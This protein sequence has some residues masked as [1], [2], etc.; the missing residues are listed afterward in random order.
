MIHLCVL[1]PPRLTRLYL[2]VIQKHFIDQKLVV[3]A[4]KTKYMRFSRAHRN[5]SD[6]CSILLQL[7]FK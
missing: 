5:N 2:V 6:D 7:C 4:G 1:F 3:N